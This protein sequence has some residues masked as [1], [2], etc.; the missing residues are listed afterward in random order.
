MPGRNPATTS[1][2]FVPVATVSKPSS[3]AR[4]FAVSSRTLLQK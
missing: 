2:A 1:E 3:P 4:A